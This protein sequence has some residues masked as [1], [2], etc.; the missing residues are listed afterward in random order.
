[1]QNMPDNNRRPISDPELD[2]RLDTALKRLPD[3]PVPSNFS[4]RVLDAV[5]LAERR[6]VGSGWRWNWRSLFPRLAVGTAVL[7]VA[8]ISLQRYEANSQRITLAKEVASVAASQPLPSVDALADLDAIQRLGQ[9]S[10]ADTELLA[11]LQ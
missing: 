4:A 10:R 1:M 8:G 9:S 3:V 2:A 11:A 5:E 6:A 7:L